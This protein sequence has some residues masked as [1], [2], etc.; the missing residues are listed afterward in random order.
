MPGMLLLEGALN[1]ARFEAS[2]RLLIARHETLRTE[3]ELVQGEPMQR[4]KEAVDFEVAY[5]EASKEEVE[6]RVRDFVQPFDLSQAPL[7][8]VELIEWAKERYV[9][10][11]DM[12]HIISDGASMDIL[13][14]EFARLYREEKL[15]ALRI[16]YK[17]YAVWQQ[18]EAYKEQMQQHE[19]YWLKAL[20]GELPVLELPTDAARPVVR[21]SDGAAF[22]FELDSH[23]RDA[24]YELAAQ[25]WIRPCIWCCWRRIRFCCI[26]TPG[27]KTLSSVRRLQAERIRT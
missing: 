8:R 14:E 2:F 12:H 6:A 1:R 26:N 23:Q 18:S 15:P 9:L 25:T 7:L 17:D 5:V 21:Q 20:D 10:L 13:V 4:V 11:L 19:A 16:Q 27:K 22:D 3:F 24:L